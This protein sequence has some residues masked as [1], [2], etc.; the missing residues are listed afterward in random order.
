VL[1]TSVL[2]TNW[3]RSVGRLIETDVMEH[4]AD[5]SERGET[6]AHVVLPIG[7]AAGT[8]RAPSPEASRR[9]PH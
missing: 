7:L 9:V 3:T 4:P 8:G 5:G 6:Q 2:D 1:P